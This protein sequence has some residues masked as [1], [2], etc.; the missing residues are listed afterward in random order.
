M[1]AGAATVKEVST[2][3]LI[4]AMITVRH[5]GRGKSTTLLL[6]R[7]RLSGLKNR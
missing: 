3:L 4:L 5:Q 6:L 1:P 2:T 7:R